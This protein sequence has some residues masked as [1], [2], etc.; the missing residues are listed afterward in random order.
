MTAVRSADLPL[1]FPINGLI[2]VGVCAAGKTT[3]KDGLKSSGIPA[4]SVA[5][6][7][8][9]VKQLY[10]QGGMGLVVLLVASWETVHHRRQ[11]AW[12]PDFYRTEWMRLQEARKEARLILHT[13]ELSRKEVADA[14][15]R[16]WDARLGL[17]P[18]WI[19]H[20]DWDGPKKATIRS[21]VAIGEP[22]QEVVA[23][24]ERGPSMNGHAG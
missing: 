12:N 5:Q 24:V 4:R 19:G 17:G 7:H 2:L 10:R 9:M 22:L 20:P 13:D 11:L 6:E 1:A 15:I 21:K 16:W 14:I 3:A 23:K 8:S 18:V